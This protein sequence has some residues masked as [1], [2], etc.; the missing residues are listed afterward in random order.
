MAP[1][2]LFATSD[3]AYGYFAGGLSPSDEILRE[4]LEHRGRPVVP[5]VW[6]GPVPHGASVV[7]R[8]TW[9]YV[10]DPERFVR[11]LD[12][13]DEQ[14]AAVAN[15]TPTVRWNLHKRYLNDLEARGVPIVPTRLLARSS[16]VTLDDVR[17]ATGWGDVVVK[18]AIGA[19]ARLTVHEAREGPEATAAHLDAV[20]AG[21]DVLVQ[22]FV[23]SVATEG[24]VSVMAAAGV[25][26][27][28]VRKRPKAGDWRVQVNFGG[29]DERIDLD[30][31]LEAVARHVLAAL[32]EVPAYA[33]IDLVRH[34][35]VLRLIE[36]ELIEPDLFLDRAP[37]TAEVLADV[38]VGAV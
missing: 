38:L 31:E 26:T 23:A 11:W 2:V 8:A 28:A 16:P 25:P 20:L 4:A 9:D 37:E 15:P 32:D 21:E 30:D 24:E 5:V 14:E 19:T 12:H 36:L 35:G 10:D 17:R 34:E 22:P 13:L 29:T 18:P 6:G 27:H 7:L 33:R 1:E 3:L